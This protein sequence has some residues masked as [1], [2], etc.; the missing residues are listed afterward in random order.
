M[1]FHI[2][3]TRISVRVQHFKALLLQRYSKLSLY[4]VVI[5]NI[6]PVLWVLET[7]VRPVELFALPN[8]SNDKKMKTQ[9]VF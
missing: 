1:A 4:L 5:N 3:L 9:H 2:D 8:R 7:S 6:K